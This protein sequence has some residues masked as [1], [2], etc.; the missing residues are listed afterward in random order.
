[1]RSSSAV[2]PSTYFVAPLPTVATPLPTFFLPLLPLSSL[3]VPLFLHSMLQLKKMLLVLMKKKGK[4]VK[5]R[6]TQRILLIS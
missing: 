3:L 2:I 6:E 1:M 4:K 5:L